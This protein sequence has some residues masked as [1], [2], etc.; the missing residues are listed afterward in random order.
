MPG[1]AVAV[2]VGPLPDRPE[3]WA[4]IFRPTAQLPSADGVAAP[5][6]VWA[7]LDCPS[8]QP[9]DPGSDAPWLLGTLTVRQERPVLLDADHVLLAWRLGREGRRA[10]TASALIG[11]DGEVC[12]RAQ[13]IWFEVAGVHSVRRMFHVGHGRA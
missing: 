5:E 2:F 1:D 6:T 12:A 3:L 8:F 13:A 7:A 9:A 10:L 4:G 11:P